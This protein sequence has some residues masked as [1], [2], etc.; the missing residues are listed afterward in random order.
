MKI[1]ASKE[2][3]GLLKYVEL[4]YCMYTS[5]IN[6]WHPPGEQCNILTGL[7]MF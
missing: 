4:K 3:Y 2:K 5:M 6:D 1:K 7:V